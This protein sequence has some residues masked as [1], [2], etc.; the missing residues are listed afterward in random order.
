L[1]DF[2]KLVELLVSVVHRAVICASR[3]PMLC[4]DRRQAQ[5]FGAATLSRR[6]EQRGGGCRGCGWLNRL[7][8]ADARVLHNAPPVV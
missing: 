8:R 1:P 5:N 7:A 6:R 4:G 2:L 3:S